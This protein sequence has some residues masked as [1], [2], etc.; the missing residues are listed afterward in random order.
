MC[1]NILYCGYGPLGRRER[2]ELHAAKPHAQHLGQ[3]FTSRGIT[4][5]RQIAAGC[6]MC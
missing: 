6:Q 4:P 2:S 1:C 3:Q 5:R